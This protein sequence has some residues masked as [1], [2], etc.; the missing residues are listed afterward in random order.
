[1]AL[2][3]PTENHPLPF[4]LSGTVTTTAAE[5]FA[6]LAGRPQPTE[7]DIYTESS[8]IEVALYS[9]SEESPDTRVWLPV[10]ADTW[11]T[12]WTRSQR[13]AGSKIALRAS[14]GS[15]TVLAVLR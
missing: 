4:G 1:V 10:P 3:L 2:T 6:G 12:A 7:V 15:H 14:S 8:D 11:Y 9:A 5:I 13:A